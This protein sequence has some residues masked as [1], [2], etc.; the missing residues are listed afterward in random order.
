MLSS[1]ISPNYR[2]WG[3]IVRFSVTSDSVY[4]CMPNLDGAHEGMIGVFLS[5]SVIPFIF[6]FEFEGD[7]NTF[8]LRVAVLQKNPV[9][10]E[11]DVP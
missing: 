9:L 8:T 2:D 7:G 3:V 10:E 6:L 11:P 1:S 4:Y 5:Y